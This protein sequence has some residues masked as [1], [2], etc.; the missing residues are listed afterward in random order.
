VTPSQ[1]RV[2]VVILPE[3]SWTVAANRW[4]EAEA[5]GFSTAWTYDHL[6]WRSLRDG[7]WFGA[8]P[9]LAA[10][11]ASTRTLRIGTLVTSPNFRHPALLAKDIM[12][13]DDISAGRID[14]GIGAG[15]V[16][17][18]AVALGGTAPSPAERGARFAEFVDALDVLLREPRASFDGNFF[19][20][21]ESRTIPGCAQR[22]RPPFTIAAA[23]RRALDVA[24]RHG[25]AWVTFGPLADGES[26]D[27]WFAGVAR[28][29]SAL[30]EA[31][32]RIDRDP[33][34]I[35]RMALVPLELG[36]P[37]SS[38]EAWDHFCGRLGELGFTDVV[39]H[40]PRPDDPALPGPDPELFDEVSRRLTGSGSIRRPGS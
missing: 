23:G 25:Q 39:L 18:D 34:S 26:S 15:G 5:R 35:D 30:D 17:F 24:A 12:T 29:S 19:L 33:G 36:W 9:L 20:A 6:S 4:R 14:L 28:Q 21:V 16:G 3:L 8:I 38:V 31:C 7:P 2:G 27:G 40:W 1:V 32:A 11:A 37:Q 22:P 10:V 13:L